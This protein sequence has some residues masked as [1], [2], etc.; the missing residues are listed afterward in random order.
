M[1]ESSIDDGEL[2]LPPQFLS[3]DY[4]TMEKSPVTKSTGDWFVKESGNG[5]KGFDFS[6]NSFGF[7]SDLSSPVDSVHGSTETESDEEDYLTELTRKMAQSTLEDDFLKSDF[8]FPSQST[9]AWV[10]TGSPQSTL[11][12]VGSGCCGCR[13]GSSRG[14]PNGTSH[15]SSPPGTWDLLYAAAGE[16]ARMRMNEDGLGYNYN[17]GLLNTPNKPSPL[18]KN[19]NQKLD[20]GFYSTQTPSLIQQQVQVTQMQRVKLQQQIIKQ[21]NQSVWGGQ[22]K[23]IELYQQHRALQM[24]QNRTRNTEI[25]GAGA[26]RPLDLPVSAWPPLVPQ[27]P[28]QPNGSAMRAVFL[29]NSG[30]R[31]ECA[32]TGVFLPRRAGCPSEPRKK[33]ACSTVLVPAR[34]AQA[35]NL[36]LDDMGTQTQQ[37]Q[38]RF[39]RNLASENDVT[40]R[41]RNSNAM[42]HQNRTSRP[43]PAMNHEIRLPQEWTY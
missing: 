30:S 10:K 19:Q 21:Q 34:V 18:L 5:F 26:N 12:A 36:K 28:Q 7:S 33:P 9:K 41:I 43:S 23:E 4:L 22:L 27:Q 35:L 6:F 14:S 2:C 38:P 40:L 11:C 29:G 39:N 8:A 32:G 24:V 31:K 25:V 3:D 13:Q 17:R 42:N 15:V 1:A 37:F 20:S 16:V